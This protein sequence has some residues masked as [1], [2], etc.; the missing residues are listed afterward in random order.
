MTETSTPVSS[1]ALEFEENFAHVFGEGV[2]KRWKNL[3]WLVRFLSINDLIEF[4]KR[5][6]DGNL[7][8][9]TS[10]LEQMRF[11]LY[12]ALRKSDPRLSNA[13]VENEA[14]KLTE[15]QVGRLL[16]LRTFQSAE[17][18]EFLEYLLAGSGLVETPDEATKKK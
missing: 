12:L 18:G 3:P 17:T 16:D 13:D 4:Q 1:A 2:T 6:P 9:D 8:I 5:Y 7:S 14:W 10:N 15:T 11:F